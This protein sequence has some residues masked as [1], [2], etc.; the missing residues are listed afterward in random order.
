MG[1]FGGVN[2]DA[3][4]LEDVIVLA[5]QKALYDEQ[6]LAMLSQGLNDY[7]LNELN[8][9]FPDGQYY[10]T[11][12]FKSTLAKFAGASDAPYI[13]TGSPLEI[14]L[15]KKGDLVTVYTTRLNRGGNNVKLILVEGARSY[16]ADPNFLSKT[17]PAEPLVAEP[18]KYTR[19]SSD[20][21]TKLMI[22]GA[23]VLGLLLSKD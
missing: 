3:Q 18:L 13:S 11:F 17:K 9:T 12:D 19:K 6:R 2:I 15:F 4:N 14:K 20:N 21:N 23:L 22:A 16:Y 1:S 7:R 10:V 5:Q 8:A